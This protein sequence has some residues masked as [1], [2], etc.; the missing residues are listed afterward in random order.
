M[1]KWMRAAVVA[2][3]ALGGV[4]VPSSASAASACTGLSG[5]KIVS[6]ADVDG[7]GRADQV[8]VRIKSSGSKATNTVRVLT[9]KGRLMSSQ[10]TVDPWS[11]SW[12]G[13]ARIDGRSGYE[14]VIPTNGQTEYRTYRVLTYRDGRLVTLKTPQSAWSWDIVAEYSGYTGWSRSTRDG[15]VLVTRK[16]AYRV[17]ET[18]RFDLRTTT[19]QWK[20]GAWSRPVASTRN[21]RASQKAAESVFGWNIPYLKRL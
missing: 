4:V 14:L 19:Y 11:K 1:K 16:T 10:V 13:A 7:D 9:A 17:D 6:R 21:A 20:N 8:G 15:K 12:H 3:V 5:C 2:T 18:S